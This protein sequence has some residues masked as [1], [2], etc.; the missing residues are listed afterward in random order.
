MT[1]GKLIPNN[2]KAITTVTDNLFEQGT[3]PQKLI[4]VFFKPTDSN[5]E[6]NGELMFGG[7]D[8]TKFIGPI[9]YQYVCAA[10]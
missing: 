2:S 8:S 6:T 5:L 10:T 1:L 3:I 9:N 4:A 7:T